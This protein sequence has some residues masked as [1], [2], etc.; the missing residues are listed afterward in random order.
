MLTIRKTGEGYYLASLTGEKEELGRND[1]HLMKKDLMAVLKPHREITISMKGVK[2]ITAGGIHILEELKHAAD[3]RKCKIRF[4]NAE[5]SVAPVLA[6][7]TQKKAQQ[8]NTLEIDE[9]FQ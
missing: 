2:S 8:H 1:C 3:A 5:P 6:E 4:I 7:L 9:L